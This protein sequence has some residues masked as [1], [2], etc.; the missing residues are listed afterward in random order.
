MDPGGHPR[1]RRPDQSSILLGTS[2]TGPR[3]VWAAGRYHTSAADVP[4]TLI[5]H[6]DGMSWSQF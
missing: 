6:W 3:D 2:A 5:L 4:H 1:P